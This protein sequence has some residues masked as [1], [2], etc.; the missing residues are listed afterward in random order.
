VIR[1]PLLSFQAGFSSHIKEQPPAA[2]ETEK[3]LKGHRLQPQVATAE[4]LG[5]NYVPG[6]VLGREENAMGSQVCHLGRS[7][8][9]F[10][11]TKSC[12]KKGA[13][14]NQSARGWTRFPVRAL[15]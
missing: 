11:L 4:G 5:Q 12:S 13:A 10:A 3:P 14:Y 6:L 15:C 7:P 1:L 2:I 9:S 8:N